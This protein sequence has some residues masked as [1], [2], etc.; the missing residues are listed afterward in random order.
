MEILN[1][2]CGAVFRDGGAQNGD[3]AGGGAGNLQGRSGI[4]QDQVH[5]LGNEPVND[6]GTG[7]NVVGSHLIDEGHLIGEHFVQGV[8]EAPGGVVVGGMLDQ[9]ADADGVGAVTRGRG[10]C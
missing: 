8:H 10:V 2:Q 5:F 1:A 3:V 6:T 9:L 4:C 7:G